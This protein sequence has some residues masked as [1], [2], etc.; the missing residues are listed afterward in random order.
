VTSPTYQ[1]RSLLGCELCILCS[2]NSANLQRHQQ[3]Q[4]LT[5]CCTAFNTQHNALSVYQQLALNTVHCSCNTKFALTSANGNSLQRSTCLYKH[6]V[7]AGCA[8][9]PCV[10]KYAWPACH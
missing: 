8:A 3:Q 7:L 5:R 6:L 1:V 2:C 10:T 9:Y 4:Q